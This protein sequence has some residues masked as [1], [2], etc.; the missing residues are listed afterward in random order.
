MGKYRP[1]TEIVHHAGWSNPPVASFPAHET[2]TFGPRSRHFSGKTFHAVEESEKN[3]RVSGL[4]FPQA[5][6][7]FRAA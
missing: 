4:L 1:C 3:S 5:F 7:D 6:G 2:V